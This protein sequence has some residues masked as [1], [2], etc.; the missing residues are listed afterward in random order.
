MVIATSPQTYRLLANCHIFNSYSHCKTC[1]HFDASGC[2][3]A[4]SIIYIAVA[5]VGGSVLVPVAGLSV[6]SIDMATRNPIH[7]MDLI[8]YATYV[9]MDSL[10]LVLLFLKQCVCARH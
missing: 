7:Y 4:K 2:R 10:V 8:T 1:G 3:Y 5:D 6:R 9:Y